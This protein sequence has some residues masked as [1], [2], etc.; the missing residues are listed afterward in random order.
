MGFK[1]KRGEKAAIAK[2]AGIAPCNFYEIVNRKRRVSVNRARLLE[3]VSGVV[4]GRP[5]FWVDWLDNETTKHPAF[6]PL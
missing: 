2:L 3:H 4:L 6:K 1:W 5:I